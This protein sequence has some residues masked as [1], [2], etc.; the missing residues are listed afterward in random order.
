MKHIAEDV[1]IGPDTTLG[2]FVVIESGA[3]IGKECQIGHHVVIHKDAEIADHVRIDAHSVVGKQPMR[4]KRS[5]FKDEKS[6]P[7]ACIGSGCMIGA[8]VVV[9]AGCEVAN[10]VLIADGAAV[11]E[12]VSVGE[13]TIIGRNATVENF[14][15]IGKKCKLET[16]CYITAYSEL[17]D[18]CF[19]APG[20][21]TTN[22]NFLG[23][24]E[25]RF[26]HFKGVVVKRGGRIGGHAIIL[27]GRT[28]GADAVVAA[29]AVVTKDVPDKVIV[30]GAPARYFRDVPE[31]QLL[32]NQGW[33]TE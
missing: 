2:E 8:Q 13:Y 17:G 12:N 25:E 22:D 27:P 24:T 18:F 9:Y 31:E 33:D 20:V 10:N 14:C 11:R 5:I 6:L 15:T 4:S 3:K 1:Q 26:K 30:V 23:R 29:G 32:E 19:I 7:P 16:N 28:I 21:H